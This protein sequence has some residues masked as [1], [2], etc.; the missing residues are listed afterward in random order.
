LLPSRSAAVRF[1]SAAAASPFPL[2]HFSRLTFLVAQ[3]T[4]EF[5]SQQG[6]RDI[7]FAIVDISQVIGRPS[8]CE[9]RI[10]ASGTDAQ[11]MQKAHLFL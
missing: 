5:Y 8:M 1:F 4:A 6:K 7:L 11:D 10:Q 3:C 2:L 9:W